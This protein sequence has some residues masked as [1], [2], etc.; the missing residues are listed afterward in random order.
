[1]GISIFIFKLVMTPLIIAGVT[2]AARRWG[3]D[4]GGLLIGL[5]L[6]SG[7]VSIFFAIEQG[8]T[9]AADAANSAM[10]GLIPVVVFYL[11]YSIALRRFSPHLAP[12]VGVAA[13]GAAVEAMSLIA[14][15]FNITIFLIP[16]ALSAGMLIL[17]KTENKN[18]KAAP[19]WWDL[20][21]RIITATALV[22]LI[23]TG[24]SKLGPLWSGLLSPFPIFTFIM[25]TFSLSQGGTESAQNFLRGAIAG[26]FS[27]YVFF[28]AVGL[29]VER[30]SLVLTYTTATVVALALNSSF[31]ITRLWKKKALSAG[32]QQ[33]SR[34]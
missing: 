13:Y 5:P 10:L 27:Y 6:T 11:S 29:L 32:C 9:F 3:D 16:L 12:I 22:I 28:I 14:P 19:A 15:G 21:L 30:T 7:P 33:T 17:G 20:P 26:L 8:R 1:M 18:G 31:L 23:T 24:A 25:A 2:L 34:V 4:I